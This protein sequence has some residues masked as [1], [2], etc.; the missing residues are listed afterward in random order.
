[1]NG[2]HNDVLYLVGNAPVALCELKRFDG[3]DAQVAFDNA[4][5]QLQDYA[6]SEDFEVPP[7]FLVLYCG[8]PSRNRFFRLK[9]VADE[10]LFDEAEY[11]ELDEIWAWERIKEFHL[12]G[13]FAEEVVSGE[14]LR[15]ILLYHLDRIENDLRIQV[16]QAV[17]LVRSDDRPA[18]LGEFAEWLLDREDALR[19]VRQ[20]YD[21]KVAEVGKDNEPTVAGEMVTQAAL[22]Y[23]NK[24][25]FLGLCEDRH[26]PGSTGSCA[27]SC[28]GAATRPRRRRLPRF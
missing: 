21:R 2:A 23:L 5:K 11:E 13:R 24:V 9:T 15:E 4:K 16:T 10:S 18:I 3:L 20:L 12:R 8:K 27:S 6:R 14:R 28:P 22:N 1:V 7:S 17:R 25:F 26:L 19:R